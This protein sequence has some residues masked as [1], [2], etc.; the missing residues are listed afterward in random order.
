MILHLPW[1]CYFA[2]SSQIANLKTYPSPSKIPIDSS[3]WVVEEE[4]ESFC[5]CVECE[6]P[7]EL[8]QYRDQ[9]MPPLEIRLE[10]FEENELDSATIPEQ[11]QERS[12]IDTMSVW[13]TILSFINFSH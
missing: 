11:Q 3:V 13:I 9:L 4:E 12:T 10:R 2:D 1:K 5:P 7:K 6:V 8:L